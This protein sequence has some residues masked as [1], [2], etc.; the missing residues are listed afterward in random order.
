MRKIVERRTLR[1]E[2]GNPS[3]YTTMLGTW[4]I[5]DQSDSAIRDG[6]QEDANRFQFAR[7]KD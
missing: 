1:R 6:Y 4:R 2:I 7:P 3:G 5:D